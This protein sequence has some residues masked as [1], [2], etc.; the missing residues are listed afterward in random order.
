MAY[1]ID[2]HNLIA[3]LPDISLEDPDDEWKLVLLLRGFAAR[4]GKRCVV[5]FD[6][7]LPGGRSR[8]SNR[9]VEV[10]FAAAHQTTADNIIKERIAA[11]RDTVA[12]TVI[13]SDNEILDAARARGMRAVLS[14][15]FV[16]ILQPPEPE[17]D[18]GI[19]DN[20]I[21]SQ[22]EIEEFLRL[23]GDGSEHQSSGSKPKTPKA[24]PRPADKK[25][26]PP[27]RP[28]PKKGE[29]L[30]PLHDVAA[31]ERLFGGNPDS[32]R[33][34]PRLKSRR[35]VPPE[36]KLKTQQPTPQEPP[37]TIRPAP[38]PP[39]PGKQS[40]RGKAQPPEKPTAPRS[41][42]EVEEWL[43]IFGADDEDE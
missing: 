8:Y 20:P 18:P 38:H 1:L 2:G 6:H 42:A 15:H 32:T 39:K 27:R 13:S 9:A 7:G 33:D 40:R 3:R 22:E 5:I 31:W 29:E 16:D 14:V 21:V 10:V 35:P 4:T 43:R 12:W 37:S 19:A 26:E 24:R 30:P 23:F 36:T 17:I 41:D 11:A 25:P 28:R 34:R